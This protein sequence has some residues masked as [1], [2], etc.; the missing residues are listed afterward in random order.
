MVHLSVYESTA[1]IR[2][3]RFAEIDYHTDTAVSKHV[4]AT[5]SRK[6]GCTVPHLFYRHDGFFYQKRDTNT[7]EIK[8]VCGKFNVRRLG[9][10]GWS[11][12]MA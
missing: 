11:E 10:L 8:K 9:S 7:A 6:G 2:S 4:L 1:L 5:R 3:R 12:H